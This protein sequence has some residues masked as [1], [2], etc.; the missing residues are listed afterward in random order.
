MTENVERLLSRISGQLFGP[1]LLE[2]KR[3]LQIPL[4]RFITCVMTDRGRKKLASLILYTKHMLKLI[5]LNGI[6]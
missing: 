2:S 4:M 3:C 5:T 6:K 1:T